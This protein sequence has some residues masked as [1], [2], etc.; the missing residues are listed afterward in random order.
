MAMTKEEMIEIATLVAQLQAQAPA[1]ATPATVSNER[2]DKRRAKLLAGFKRKGFKDVILRDPTDPSKP[3]N[4]RPFKLW[5]ENG[6]VVRKGEKSVQGLFHIS[7]TD[8]LPVNKPAAAKAAAKTNA[9][10]PKLQLKGFANLA[11]AMS[12][13]NGQAQ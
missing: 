4:V 9:E 10:K 12:Q 5:I 8:E 7:Q 6:R 11:H 2:T 13:G 3:H 1:K